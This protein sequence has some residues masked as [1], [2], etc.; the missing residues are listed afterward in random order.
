M[1]R[2]LTPHEARVGSWSLGLVM[3]ACPVLRFRLF[4]VPLNLVLACDHSIWYLNNATR[5]TSILDNQETDSRAGNKNNRCERKF[6]KTANSLVLSSRPN[7]FHQRLSY[8]VMALETRRYIMVACG[9]ILWCKVKSHTHSSH[10]CRMTQLGLVL[11]IPPPLGGVLVHPNIFYRY[12]LV[13]QAG[14][15]L[16]AAV[17][18]LIR[19]GAFWRRCCFWIANSPLKCLL[20]V[21]A[22]AE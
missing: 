3:I 18:W 4:Y 12:I 13:A 9:T 16:L 7:Y 6:T 22:Y 14:T 17:F 8:H 5:C 1:C 19:I 15:P 20:R 11:Y 2:L 10:N 21:M